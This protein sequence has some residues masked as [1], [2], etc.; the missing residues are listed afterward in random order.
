MKV[1][2]FGATGALG[3]ECLRQAIEAGHE[4]TVL[5]R[6]PSKLPAEL[7]ERVQLVEGDALD[8]DAVARAIPAGTEAVLFAVGVDS[9]SPEDLCTDVTRHILTALRAAG[10]G[11]FVWCGGGSNLLPKDVVTFGAKFV[12]FFATTFMGLRQR[13]KEHQLALLTESRDVAWFGIRPLQ[14]N[15]GPQRS[16]YRLGY[17]AFN[18]FSKIHFTD[19]AHAMI[20]MLDD[21]TWLHEAPIVQ[22]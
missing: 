13:D 10:A 11:R 8:A 14:M 19:C 4:V 21:D 3:S 5:A 9:K 1:S 20:G 22:Y 6:S 18:G 2:L 12:K 7:R 15:A 16:D 17:H